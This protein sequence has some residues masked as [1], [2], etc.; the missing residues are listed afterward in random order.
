MKLM[1]KA[2]GAPSLEPQMNDSMRKDLLSFFSTKEKE[3]ESL[4]LHPD[5]DFENSVVFIDKTSLTISRNGPQ[6]EFVTPAFPREVGEKDAAPD[7][8][9]YLPNEWSFLRLPLMF[10]SKRR[11][12]YLFETFDIHTLLRMPDFHLPPLSIPG[13]DRTAVFGLACFRQIETDSLIT[14]DADMTRSKVQKAVVVLSSEPISFMTRNKL[15]LITRSYFNQRDFSDKV[16]LQDFW[17]YL[18]TKT[19]EAHSSF[20]PH[21]GLPL[22]NFFK[23]F[24]H[25]ALQLFKLLLLEKKVLFY[26]KKVEQLSLYQYSLVSLVPALMENLKFMGNSE[27]LEAQG[28]KLP[29][30]LNEKGFPLHLF[31]KIDTGTLEI[32]DS[33]LIPLIALT[34]S[35][36]VFVESIISKFQSGALNA[37]SP[38]IDPDEPTS[39]EELSM[40]TYEEFEVYLLSLMNT[41]R[42]RSKPLQETSSMGMKR[43]EETT[44]G[45]KRLSDETVSKLK[46]SEVTIAK[47][48]RVSEDS[49]RKEARASQEWI[50]K[51]KR[52]SEE[53]NPP[54]V[55][56]TPV[57]IVDHLSDF[58]SAWVKAW[59][60]TRNFAVWNEFWISKSVG[61]PR[62]GS[63]AISEI[64]S[65]VSTRLV[66]MRKSMA[67]LQQNIGKALSSAE[68]T[69]SNAFN[70]VSSTV[71]DPNN[72][73]YI[74]ATASSMFASVSSWYTERKKDI[75]TILS[76]K[77]IGRPEPPKDALEEAFVE[78]QSDLTEHEVNSVEKQSMD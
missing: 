45:E 20:E 28:I 36:R 72:H 53:G 40:K 12:I 46:T 26:G 31:H 51:D 55:A 22:A 10:Y 48:P 4:T 38:D 43:S 15:E 30:F 25:K 1:K 77:P 29:K 67:P 66:E 41:I 5:E 32:R 33:T 13:N 3:L 21:R 19:S 62:A 47:E 76:P 34:S 63:S 37:E 9:L 14:K 23:T 69:L 39:A 8:S 61:H 68:S 50:R 18:K 59:K 17:S 44:E 42:I 57:K 58:N 27:D 75:G 7:G 78:I 16:I 24:K 35:D 74:Q 2:Q 70:T 71:S 6:V 56:Q 49:S 73:Q 64:Q 65:V 60:E 52:Q 54:N 11:G